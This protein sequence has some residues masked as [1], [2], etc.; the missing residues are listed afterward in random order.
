MCNINLIFESFYRFF[1]SN[2]VLTFESVD[3]MCKNNL[4]LTFESLHEIQSLTFTFKISNKICT[5]NV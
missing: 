5:Y 2:V 1:K 4:Y 3:E